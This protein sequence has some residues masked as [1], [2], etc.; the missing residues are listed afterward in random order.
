MRAQKWVNGR[1]HG[2]VANVRV[3]GGVGSGGRGGG[4]GWDAAVPA[5]ARLHG[6]RRRALRGGRRVSF[7]LSFLLS[8]H[9]CALHFRGQA[10][11]EGKGVLASCRHCADS[12]QEPDCKYSRH[13]LHRSH[14]S[15]E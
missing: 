9:W 13:D 2:R 4:Y 6:N 10:W 12:G 5:H 8:F 15:T 1:L 7:P 11:A 3:P 14:T